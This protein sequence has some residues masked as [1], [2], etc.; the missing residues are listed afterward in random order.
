MFF[1]LQAHPAW[2][3]LDLVLYLVFVVQMFLVDLRPLGQI[4]VLSQLLE[5][6]I[7]GHQFAQAFV[8]LLHHVLA[9]L[10]QVTQGFPLL[11]RGSPL[12]VVLVFFSE[13]FVIFFLFY[14]KC[15]GFLGLSVIGSFWLG[16]VLNRR[17]VF[18]GPVDSFV[19]QK[20]SVGVEL[21]LDV[22]LAVLRLVLEVE[23]LFEVTQGL[24]VQARQD[25]S[26]LVVDLLAPRQCFRFG[27][28]LGSAVRILFFGTQLAT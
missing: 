28:D 19:R 15:S 22:D 1:Q 21:V 23:A 17:I 10:E 24:L 26:A 12:L 6:R 14:K 3:V 16:W 27:P 25:L 8:V 20:V 4:I 13:F 9:A 2:L 7:Q 11:E 18:A 5:Q